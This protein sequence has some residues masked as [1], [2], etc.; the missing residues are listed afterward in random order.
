MIS[1]LIGVTIDNFSK[2][3]QHFLLLACCVF[4]PAKR[5]LACRLLV[6]IMFCSLFW[7]FHIYSLKIKKDAEMF[8]RIN[9]KGVYQ[10]LDY[11]SFFFAIHL[12]F[13]CAEKY[14]KMLKKMVLTRTRN[15]NYLLADRNT[16]HWAKTGISST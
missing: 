2:G 11:F 13:V 10:R 9:E 4:Q 1:I 12:F 3:L 8:R 14:V 5:C 6:E 15:E 16:Q 7:C